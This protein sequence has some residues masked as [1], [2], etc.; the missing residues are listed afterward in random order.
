MVLRFGCETEFVGGPIDGHTDLMAL[1]LE[2]YLG[3]LLVPETG[4]ANAI[5]TAISRLFH[6]PRR[7]PLAI[8]ELNVR[9]GCRLCYRYLGTQ[10]VTEEQL[11]SR[12]CRGELV[13]VMQR[14]AEAT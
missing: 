8:Y 1:P 3:V 11:R 7:S 6:S 2:P 13:T 9:D 4:P 14:R 5:L 10:S 12:T